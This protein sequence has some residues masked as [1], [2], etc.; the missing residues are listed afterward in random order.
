MLELAV[1]WMLY[2]KKDS[3]KLLTPIFPVKIK[4][5]NQQE[6]ECNNKEELW[7]HLVDDTNAS[8]PVITRIMPVHPNFFIDYEIIQIISQF[9]RYKNYGMQFIYDDWDELPNPVMDAFD[10]ISG[11][12]QRH[13][14]KM[15][16]KSAG[17]EKITKP[18]DGNKITKARN[19]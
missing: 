4:N 14:Q 2:D 16:K 12:I 9:V 19:R 17:G 13:E 1:K 6:V 3:I 11:E 7:K 10:Y 18:T 5:Y 8:I 15:M